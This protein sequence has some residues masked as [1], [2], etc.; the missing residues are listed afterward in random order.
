MLQS[1]PIMLICSIVRFRF[2]IVSLLLTAGFTLHAEMEGMWRFEHPELGGVFFRIKSDGS[3]T[4]F[5]EEGVD[6]AI[7]GG[8]WSEIP[9]GLEIKYDN[10]VVLSAG[11]MEPG[12]A[13]V[14]VVMSPGHMV[15]PGESVCVAN[16]VDDRAIGSMTV[17]QEKSDDDEDRVGYFGGWEGELISGDKFYFVINEDRTAGMSY[18]F[19]DKE[20]DFEGFTDVVGFWK[21]DGEKLHIYWN[22]GSFTSIETNGRRIEQTSFSA[23]DLLE[24]ARGYTCRIIPFRTQDLPTDWYKEF[25]G[26]FVTRMPIIVLRQLSVVKKFFR[27]DWYVGEGTGA[28]G[29]TSVIK[30]KR[31]GKAWTNRYG[32]VKGDWY[33]G[34]DSVSIYWHNGVKEMLTAVGNQFLINSYNPNQPVSGRPARIEVANPDNPDTMGYYLNRKRE[35]LDP[36]RYFRGLDLPGFGEKNDPMVEGTPATEVGNEE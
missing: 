15:A 6:T 13:D 4:Y 21:K 34:S 27:G 22:D 28:D 1:K 20:D 23:G 11:E 32:G 30:L 33:P 24:E 12:V 8:M 14:R 18:S 2:F 3:S 9:T 25:R 35:L 19:S 31:F 29:E 16:L 10:G 26:D 17:D 36:R 5:L 7:H